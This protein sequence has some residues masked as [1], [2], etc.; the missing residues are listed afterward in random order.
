[1]PCT[2]VCKFRNFSHA[3]SSFPPRFWKK[4][5]STFPGKYDN[6]LARGRD[7]L[8]EVFGKEEVF[9]DAKIVTD[10]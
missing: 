6:I 1:M 2:E 5:V 7:G 8:S 3:S 9:H 10:A 4:S